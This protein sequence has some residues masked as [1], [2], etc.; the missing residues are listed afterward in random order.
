[1]F[2]VG[3]P[4]TTVAARLLEESNLGSS[5]SLQQSCP[6]P[7]GP[8]WPTQSSSV[9]HHPAAC[10][11]SDYT[12]PAWWSSSWNLWKTS[13]RGTRK[14]KLRGEQLSFPENKFFLF[15]RWLRLECSWSSLGRGYGGLTHQ[16]SLDST[17]CFFKFSL[18]AIEMVDHSLDLQRHRSTL[19]KKKVYILCICSYS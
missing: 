2:A 16:N 5:C 12:S 9:F 1:M 7:S 14:R 3:D 8:R 6:S 11:G 18:S 10:R 4:E 17:V 13:F 19:V 15:E